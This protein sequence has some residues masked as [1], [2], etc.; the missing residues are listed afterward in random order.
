ML[1]KYVQCSDEELMSVLLF[2][3]S[4]VT[5]VGPHEMQQ[6]VR[7]V[8]SADARIELSGDITELSMRITNQ[9]TDLTTK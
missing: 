7:G 2:V 8:R 6:A 9:N 1:V 4:Q 3:S 5:R